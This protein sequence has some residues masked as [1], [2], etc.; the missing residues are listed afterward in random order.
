MSRFVSKNIVRQV[1]ARA[2]CMCEYCKLPDF[3]AFASFE[4][5]HI[6]AKAHSGGSELENL[7]WACPLCN[8][9]KGPNLTSIDP[10]TRKI[11]KLFHPRQNRWSTHFRL[12][13]GLIIPRT[14]SARATIAL[15]KMNLPQTFGL[16]RA[17]EQA[18]PDYAARV[19]QWSR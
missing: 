7:A 14:G 13:E 19:I 1:Q 10:D 4:V 17:L 8:L 11:R 12:S 5:D 9:H 6:I 2:N 18:D 15:L 16:R 3:L